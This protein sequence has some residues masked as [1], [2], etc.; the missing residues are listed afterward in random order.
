MA[1]ADLRTQ[2]ESLANYLPQGRA[3]GSKR[4]IGSVAHQLLEGLGGELV[5]STDLVCEF[6]DEI[7]PDETILFLSEWESAL[8]I[9]DDCFLNVTGTDAERRRNI[10]AKLVSLGVQT[11]ADFVALALLF[12]ITANIVAGSV[13][14]VF[15][16]KFPMIFFP[17][18]RAAFHTII[19]DLSEP[20]LNVFPYT[21]PTGFPI[22]FQSEEL[23]LVEC[24]FGKV[25]PANVD[26]LFI[27]L[28]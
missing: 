12:G 10:L 25:K 8:G 14:G 5:R 9:P 16:F 28:P 24:L 20:P 27:E 11:A 19:V 26:L 22:L 17:D 23:A 6:R 7:L 3:F 18:A 21:G 4:L 2:A 13:H 15:P 1:G